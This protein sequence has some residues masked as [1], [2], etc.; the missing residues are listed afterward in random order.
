L[1]KWRDFNAPASLETHGRFRVVTVISGGL[2]L[3][4]IEGDVLSL[5]AG[6]TVLLPACLL[7]VSLEAVAPGTEVIVSFVPDLERD[8]RAPLR[9]AGH[10]DDAIARLFGPPGIRI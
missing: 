1:V 2:E 6:E 5:K 8:V 10:P 3:R 9:A 7:G 4:A